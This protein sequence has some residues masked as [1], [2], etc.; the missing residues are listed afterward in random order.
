MDNLRPA[1]MPAVLERT[2]LDTTEDSCLL[3]IYEAIANGIYSTQ[4]RWKE[5]VVSKGRVV[6]RIQSDDFRAT[7]H[8]NGFGLDEVN[9]TNFL[10]PFTGF[11]LKKGGKGF[12]RFIAFKVF[13]SVVYHSLFQSGEELAGR[14]FKFDIHSK[15]Q[16]AKIG[17]DPELLGNQTGCHVEYSEPKDAYSKTIQSLDDIDIV[18]RTIRY[19]LPF[20]LS[21]QMPQISINVDGAEFDARQHFTEFFK[22]DLEKELPVP[23]D[24]STQTFTVSISKVRRE[25]LFKEHVALLFADDRIIGAGRKIAGKIGNKYFEDDEGNKV[26]YLVSIRGEFLDQRVNTAR[27]QIDASTEEVDAIVGAATDL[28]L[29]L[30]AE[31]VKRHRAKQSKG[32][33]TGLLR[34]P[35]LRSALRGQSIASYVS[36]KPMSWKTENFVSDLALQRI[37]DQNAWEQELAEGLENPQKLTDMR[38]KIISQLDQENKDALAAYVAHRKSVIDLADGILGMQDD[39]KMSLEDIFH[40]LVHPRHADSDNTRFY[41]HNLWLLD[42]RLSFFSYCSSDRTNH[43]GRRKKGD[44]VGDLVFFDD[45]SIYQEGDRDAIVLVEFKRPARDDYRFGNVQ[46]DPIQ[47]V[48]ETAVQI[49]ETGRLISTTGRTLEVPKGVRMYA[50]VV[51]DLEPKLR[52]VCESHDMDDTWDQ[53]GY[54]RYHERKDLFIEVVGYSKMIDDAKK[55]NAAFFDVLLGELVV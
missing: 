50:Y 11:R 28:I 2:K 40:D 10:T 48:I 24:G 16:I 30:E 17:D 39:G 3:P 41:E 42:E 12:G 46:H 18:E 54:F 32:L 13:G 8:D 45:C 26:I 20:F 47:Q 44:K 38:Q 35:L 36:N 33:T 1:D 6:V 23:I 49:R 34:N 19:F 5:H 55:R 52:S 53:R 15:P 4:A 43:G 7:V 9:Y 22:T 37:R 21:N 31:F 29:G 25:N 27:T 51:A 14:S